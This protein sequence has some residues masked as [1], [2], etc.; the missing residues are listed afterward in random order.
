MEKVVKVQ[1][2]WSVER[3]SLLTN[4]PF[5]REGLGGRTT[6]RSRRRWSEDQSRIKVGYHS[7]PDNSQQ[8]IFL[9]LTICEESLKHICTYS[10]RS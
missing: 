4:I 10:I 5:Q 6:V 3:D 9:G 8:E 2:L 1:L 7:A